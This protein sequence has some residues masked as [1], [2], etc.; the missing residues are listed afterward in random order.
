MCAI[1]AK[2]LLTGSIG[3]VPSILTYCNP[4]LLC[5]KIILGFFIIPADILS[6]FDKPFNDY[7]RV[8]KLAIIS[9]I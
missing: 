5:L 3:A 1:R 2:K 8:T 7:E 6:F 9:Y 4:S